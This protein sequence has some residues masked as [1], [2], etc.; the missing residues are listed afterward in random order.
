MPN[1]LK[2]L[3]LDEVWNARLVAEWTVTRQWPLIA[4]ECAFSVCFQR[5]SNELYE[6][7]GDAN[8]LNLPRNSMSCDAYLTLT[9]S[10]LHF[11]P[12]RHILFK[13]YEQITIFAI[14]PNF[15]A[16]QKQIDCDSMKRRNRYFKT[17]LVLCYC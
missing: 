2:R 6:S 11:V 1:L 8:Y 9:C 10:L 5:Q 14:I 7:R 16:T 15:F 12:K 4:S 17:K 13:K 3:I